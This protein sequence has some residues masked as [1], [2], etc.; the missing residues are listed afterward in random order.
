MQNLTEGVERPW[1]L[2]EAREKLRVRMQH[3][4][5]HLV[6]SV[7][8]CPLPAARKLIQKIYKER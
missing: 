6:H 4:H 1:S 7:S 8:K 2:E 5:E 3:E